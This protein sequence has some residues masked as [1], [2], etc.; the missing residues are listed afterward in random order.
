LYP[1]ANNII[2]A[3]YANIRVIG[4]QG[5]AKKACIIPKQN[6]KNLAAV[7]FTHNMIGKIKIQNK[8]SKIC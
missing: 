8:E 3:G 2:V 1:L 6:I 5:S 7:D 4:G